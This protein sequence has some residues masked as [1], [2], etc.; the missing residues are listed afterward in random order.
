[1]SGNGYVTR[2]QLRTGCYREYRTVD[3]PSGR[4]Y[5]L[6]TL[7]EKQQADFEA[8]AV[9]IA[10]VPKANRLAAMEDF[11]RRG[12]RELLCR[13]LV[14]GPS[15]E[16]LYSDTEAET[17]GDEIPAPD[18]DALYAVA[19]TFCGIKGERAMTDDVEGLVKNLLG[20]AADDSP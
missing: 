7:S 16:R 9:H 2:E 20:M 18:A 4:R 11:V 13:A 8:M 15:G 12:R 5:C 6:Q 19:E 14:A 1:M 17:L 3:V 10:T